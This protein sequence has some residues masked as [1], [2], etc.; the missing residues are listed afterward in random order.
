LRCRDLP[1]GVENHVPGEFGDFAGAQASLYREENDDAIAK[2]VSGRAGVGEE[3]GQ[4]FVVENFRLLACHL[5]LDAESL[6]RA[7]LVVN[8]E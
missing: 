6:N 8:Q 2:R 3:L 7:Q 4:L 1:T 5:T